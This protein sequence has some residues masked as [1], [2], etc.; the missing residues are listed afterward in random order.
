MLNL[1]KSSEKIWHLSW[2]PFSPGLPTVPCYGGQIPDEYCQNVGA[3][4]LHP[5]PNH[6][7]ETPLQV[8]QANNTGAQLPPPSSLTGGLGEAYCPH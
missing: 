4:S 5:T 6:K 8:W 3:P 1:G 2:D 7:V